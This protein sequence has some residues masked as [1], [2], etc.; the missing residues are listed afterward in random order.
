MFTSI[1]EEIKRE[2][3]IGNMVTRLII[4]NV[5]IFV[6]LNL[7]KIALFLAG[8][9]ANTFYEEVLYP[10]TLSSDWKY[11]LTHPWSIVTAMFVH[12]DFWHVLYNM[13][14]LLWF[15]RIVGDLVGDRRIFPLYMLGGLVGMVAFFLGTKIVPS[16]SGEV[17]AWGAS[18]AVMAIVVAAGVFNPDGE[19]NV[20]FIGNVKLKYVVLALIFLDMIGIADNINTGGHFAHLG[21]ALFGWLFATRLQNGSDWGAPINHLSEKI[22]ELWQNLSKKKPVEQPKMKVAYKNPN[23]EPRRSPQT[24]TPARA[25][26]DEMDYQERLD[27]ILD[28]I[29]RFGLDKLTYEERNFLDKIGKK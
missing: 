26:T 6:F 10:L 4:I 9:P 11:I 20:L 2:F 22:T 24:K 14:F 17:Y 12:E 28:K 5:A 27:A 1:W 19:M 18:A 7:I 15:G 16:L 3:N 13:M 21:G 25:Q 23:A 8:K 29:K